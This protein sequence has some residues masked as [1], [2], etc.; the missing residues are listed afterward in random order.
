MCKDS[1]V[2][3][4]AEA[5]RLPRMSA[6]YGF[7]AAPPGS[8]LQGPHASLHPGPIVNNRRSTL[9]PP[10]P[11]ASSPQ[12]YISCPPLLFKSC[13]RYQIILQS[14]LTAF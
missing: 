11:G 12:V 4:Q 5:Q 8:A 2:T 3:M 1:V 10:M 14:L 9:K 7:I 6:A 13:N